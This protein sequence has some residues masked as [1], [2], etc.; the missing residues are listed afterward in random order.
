MRREM[1]SSS[2][3]T[4]RGRQY[5]RSA[6]C[7]AIEHIVESKKTTFIQQSRRERHKTCQAGAAEIRARTRWGNHTHF[8]PIPRRVTAHLLHTNSA[9]PRLHVVRAVPHQAARKESHNSFEHKCGI[10]QIRIT[11]KWPNYVGTIRV[12]NYDSVFMQ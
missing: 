2:V 7:S 4:G 12:T 11:V 1:G 3:D 8:Q 9:S 6:Q 5:N 10:S